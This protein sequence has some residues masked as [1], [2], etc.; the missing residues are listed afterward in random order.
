MQGKA[1]SRLH[2]EIHFRR[3]NVLNESI[4]GWN[5]IYGSRLKMNSPLIVTAIKT[6]LDLAGLYIAQQ[7][8]AYGERE[9][10]KSVSL[11][12]Y[13]CGVRN[14]AFSCRRRGKTE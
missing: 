2:W 6:V 1:G 14:L 9:E 4:K 3:I 13:Y 11:N 10:K 7:P 5:N 12:P 8:S